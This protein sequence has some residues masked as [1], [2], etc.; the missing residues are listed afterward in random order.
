[1]FKLFENP[2]AK[3]P[4]S[5]RRYFTR[6]W[7]VTEVLVEYC[8]F[9][10]F[11][12]MS[13]QLIFL[14]AQHLPVFCFSNE[15]H[16]PTFPVLYNLCYWKCKSSVKD[17]HQ[18]LCQ[19]LSKFL[20]TC[21]DVFIKLSKVKVVISAKLYLRYLPIETAING[22]TFFPVLLSWPSE[23]CRFNMCLS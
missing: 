12:L 8:I 10:H 5:T 15:W 23:F 3:L 21:F 20:S 6:L 4:Q 2:S 22:F 1:M 18:W 16:T 7:T 11:M 17:T 19:K 9:R 13:L 14:A